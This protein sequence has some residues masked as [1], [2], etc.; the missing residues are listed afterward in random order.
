MKVNEQLFPEWAKA[1]AERF[2]ANMAVNKLD[3]EGKYGTDEYGA[4]IQRFR[5]ALQREEELAKKV[6]EE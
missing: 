1:A 2:I 3:R 4:A 6:W 5:D